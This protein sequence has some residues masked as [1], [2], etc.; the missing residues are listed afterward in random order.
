M[1]TKGINR[2]DFLTK[3]SIGL[4]GVGAGMMSNGNFD[5]ISH[6]ENN[7][8]QPKIKEYRTLG[9]TGFKVSDIGCGPA[10]MTNENV[11]KF[12]INAGVNVFDTAEFYS[13][14]KNELFVGR[15]IKDFDRKSL[16]IN[17]KLMISE[18]DTQEKIVARVRKC[19]ERLDT[20]YL[21]GLMLWNPG[22]M[23]EVKNEVF[24]QAFLQLKNEGRVKFCGISCHGAEHNNVLKENM[25]KII[26]GAIDDGRFDLA[27]FVYNYVQ[28]EMG[29]NILKE[30]SKHNIGALLMKTDPFS[31]RY[32]NV[33]EK[34]KN[35]TKDNKPIDE[36]TQKR[37]EIVVEKQ[38]KAELFLADKK[39]YNNE[40][41]RREATIRFVL[42][43][44]A[45]SSVLISFETFDEINNHVI[46]SGSK[47]T[48]Q[49]RSTIKFFKNNFN[50]LYCRHAC[51]ICESQCPHGV[52]INTI[53]RYNHY[54]E[55]QKREKYAIQQYNELVGSKTEKCLD[56]EGFCESAC[57]YGVII[58]DLLTVAH[59][60]LTLNIT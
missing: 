42:D 35:L 32:L 9:R 8:D 17:T 4:V 54:F 33:F 24:H 6:N 14:G 39:I 44:P 46:L 23:A 60:N 18:H 2:R 36:Y 58:H 29:N 43:N 57:P 40:Q 13:N 53:M 26:C 19:L 7:P 56:C 5:D 28:Q 16:F 21:D 41:G 15:S 25:E 45:V 3:S 27:L 12:V 47:L 49:D 20:N 50:H 30:C 48:S 11:M 10:I 52:P 31:K 59:N 34:I 38:K 37:Y 22:S 55:A 1:K 51:G